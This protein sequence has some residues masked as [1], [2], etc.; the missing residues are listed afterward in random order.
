MR[1]DAADVASLEA[2]GRLSAVFLHEMGHVL[3]IGSMW[4][5]LGLLQNPTP[6]SGAALDTYFSG[7]GGIAGFDA[8]GGSTYT[9][10]QKV[11]VENTGGAGT[12]NA[13]WRD[14]VLQNELMTGYLSA[15]V[16]P[17]SV[18]T[19]RSLGDLGYTVNPAAADPFFLTLSVRAPGST[20]PVGLRM[21]D[22]VWQG[23][24]YSI[25]RQGRRTRLRR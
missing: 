16:T 17:L 8:I 18:L 15:G 4:S 2:S 25:D 6:S 14:S 9:G 13:H 5:T 21:H 23:P 20:Q 1:F 12:A 11:P 19:V 3:G 7:A 10:G 24:Q 22:D